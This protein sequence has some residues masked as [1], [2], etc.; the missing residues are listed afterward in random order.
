MSEPSVR[1]GV[2]DDAR[3][4]AEI[5]VAGWRHAY[6]SLVPD[7]VLAELSVDAREAIWART[8]AAEDGSVWVAERPGRLLGFVSSGP[9][10]DA[11]AEPDTGQVYAIYLEPDEIG[12][13]LGRA[14]FARA[15]EDLRLRG[16]RRATL[17]VMASNEPGRRFYEAAGWRPDGASQTEEVRGAPIEEVRYAIDLGADVGITGSP[18]AS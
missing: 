6:R 1:R 9:S 13:G 12:R 2:P 14:L 5:H 8:L 4:I 16:F 10:V 18:P 7:H 3:A 11:G 15:T 17:W